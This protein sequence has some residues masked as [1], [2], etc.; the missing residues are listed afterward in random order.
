MEKLTKERTGEIAFLLLLEEKKKEGLQIPP[1]LFAKK[2]L[3]K[4]SK[5]TG[6]SKEELKQFIKDF[7]QRYLNEVFD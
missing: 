2:G 5:K 6:I 3:K 7:C 4:L 1:T